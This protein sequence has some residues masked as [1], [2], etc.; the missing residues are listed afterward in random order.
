MTGDRLHSQVK[1]PLGVSIVAGYWLLGAVL[2][3]V[4]LV[5]GLS[6]PAGG[7]GFFRGAL[8][9]DAQHAREHFGEYLLLILIFTGIGLGLWFLKSLARQVV[10]VITGIHLLLQAIKL[11][12]PA[13]VLAASP[14]RPGTAFFWFTTAMSAAIF[15]YM[16][17]PHVKRAFARPK[18]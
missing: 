5:V 4:M 14:S 1:R 10:M 3:L 15:L 11:A 12:R 13:A 16:C 18:A 8:A 7:S 6:Q 2:F 9:Q 17:T